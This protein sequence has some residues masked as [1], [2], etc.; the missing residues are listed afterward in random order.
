MVLT[1]NVDFTSWLGLREN[2]TGTVIWPKT[3]M[4]SPK[5]HPSRGKVNYLLR[6]ASQSA[7]RKPLKQIAGVQDHRATWRAKTIAAKKT[8]KSREL[9]IAAGFSAAVAGLAIA[10]VLTFQ[11]GQVP[12]YQA[13]GMVVQTSIIGL[14]QAPIAEFADMPIF[15]LDGTPRIQTQAPGVV[16]SQD[17]V[18]SLRS[19]AQTTSRTPQPAIMDRAPLWFAAPSQIDSYNVVARALA[20]PEIVIPSPVITPELSQPFACSSCAPAFPQFGQVKFDVQSTDPDAA[21]VQ[22]LMASLAQYQSTVRQSQIEVATSQVRFYRASDAPA[23]ASLAALYNADL[24]DLTWFAPADDIAKIDVIL[25]KRS[26]VPAS[27]DAR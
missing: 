13:G 22:N 10:G 20:A 4:T 21:Y 27:E 19:P 9:R 7:S 5:R 6:G 8:K 3:V 12:S 24:V 14:G 1:E 11:L 16:I 17:N 26:I 23:A 25:A 18:L 2:A 15:N